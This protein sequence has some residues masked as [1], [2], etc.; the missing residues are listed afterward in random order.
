M[1]ILM[2]SEKLDN[3]IDFVL[4]D[5]FEGLTDSDQYSVEKS[6]R[7]WFKV[8]AEEEYLFWKAKISNK[9]SPTNH[10]L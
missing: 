5:A 2:T 9:Q 6:I 10:L 3:L 7:A 1:E 8:T 4:K